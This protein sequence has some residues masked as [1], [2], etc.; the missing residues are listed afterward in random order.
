MTSKSK[1]KQSNSSEQILKIRVD[2]PFQV[3]DVF[4]IPAKLENDGQHLFNVV[5]IHNAF[6]ELGEVLWFNLD[7][8]ED[9]DR[10]YGSLKEHF[11]YIM[12]LVSKN[13]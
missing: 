6:I 1:Q 10:I 5:R 3:R 7:Q 8:S 12:E 2:E 11:D 13:K 4:K 9:K